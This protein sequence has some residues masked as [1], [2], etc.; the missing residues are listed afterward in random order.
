V[1]RSKKGE[2]KPPTA[3]GDTLEDAQI[4]IEHTV[5]RWLVSVSSRA[6]RGAS[7]STTTRIELGGPDELLQH[8]NLDQDLTQYL[9][10]HLAHSHFLANT[11]FSPESR[12]RATLFRAPS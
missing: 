3:S 1:T 11:I 7:S 2:D 12:C 6:V 8:L 9:N 5:L 10:L 4:I